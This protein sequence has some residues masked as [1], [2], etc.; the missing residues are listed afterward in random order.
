MSSQ[1]TQTMVSTNTKSTEK[2]VHK[3]RQPLSQE[4]RD[5][6]VPVL[7][8]MLADS[9][10]LYFQV[11]QAHWNV[12]GNSFIGLHKLCDDIAADVI[13]YIDELAE[14]VAQLGGQVHGS[15]HHAAKVSRLPD[16]PPN[17]TTGESHVNAL[18]K[19]LS[20]FS[21]LA[22]TAIDQ[23]D[24]LGD[25]VSADM[26]TT[27]TASVDKWLWFVESHSM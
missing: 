14:R 2:A 5:Q 9:S 11:K 18:S 21:D 6:V 19:A 10:D 7:S 16:Y 24:E 4:V 20:Q 26:L 8:H 23:T 1:G 15:I 13:D 3:T 25:P 17:I 22:R 27:I 12:K